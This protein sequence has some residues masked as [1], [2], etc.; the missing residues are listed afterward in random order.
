M[1][2]LYPRHQLILPLPPPPPPRARTHTPT[3]QIIS[4]KK[5]SFGFVPHASCSSLPWAGASGG[6]FGMLANCFR[7]VRSGNAG[8]SLDGRGQRTWLR[9]GGSG[10]GPSSGARA[11]SSGL[12]LAAQCGRG[13]R[14]GKREGRGREGGGGLGGEWMCVRPRRPTQQ[15]LLPECERGRGKEGRA[16]WSPGW[17]IRRP[18]LCVSLSTRPSTQ[19]FPCPWESK[20]SELANSCGDTSPSSWALFV[21]LARSFFSV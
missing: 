11:R 17:P 5:L 8:A 13:C 2:W 6:R 16:R 21:E 19:S 7:R 3:K 12:P 4:L 10:G 20:N 14:R 9:G 15:Q 1:G 18:S